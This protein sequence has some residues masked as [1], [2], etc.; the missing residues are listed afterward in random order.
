[1]IKPFLQGSQPITLE[2][3]D[4]ANRGILILVNF[5]SSVEFLFMQCTKNK[6]DLENCKTCF[7]IYL[8]I[9]QYIYLSII[10]SIPL[11]LYIFISPF[12]IRVFLS[13]YIS[14]YIS[15]SIYL[16]C[17][18]IS[19]LSIYLSIVLFINDFQRL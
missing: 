15:L 6:S 8:P 16:S 1:M 11:F 2:G 12:I 13:I 4:L 17:N 14:V 5:S 19:Y 10:L 9:C 18:P 7:F 3:W